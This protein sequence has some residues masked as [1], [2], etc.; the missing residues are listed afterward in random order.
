[1]TSDTPDIRLTTIA[2]IAPYVPGKSKLRGKDAPI[3]LSSNENPFGPSPKAITAASGATKKMH[4]Y[5][6]AGCDAL[7][8]A[9]AESY[10]IS[11]DRIVCGHG[12]DELITL[13]CQAYATVGDEV[14]YS[15]HGFLMY[16]IAAQRVGATPVKA[17]EKDL[18]ADVDALLAAVTERT[19]IVFIANPNNPTGSYLT[20]QEMRQL[21]EGLPPHVLL[22]I[23]AAYGEYVTA[24][25]YS[26][27]MGMVEQHQNVVMTRTFSKIYGLG[28]LRLGW[29][30]APPAIVETLQR[31]RDPFNVSSVAQAAGIAA[32]EDIGFVKRSLEH[33]T[34]WRQNLTEDL[35]SMGLHVYPSVANFVLV[36]F[37]GTFESSSGKKVDLSVLGGT[38]YDKSATAAY[39]F[40]KTHGILVRAM[41]AYGLP[42][43]LRITI[44]TEPENQ[45]L[46][47]ALEQFMDQRT[48]EDSPV[49]R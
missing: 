34:T 1:M 15:A 31:V 48:P 21:R 29:A 39:Q 38:A 30:Y 43:C 10:D 47:E 19:R 41:Q 4:R 16:P 37:P 33:T 35:S 40:L 6:E 12:S 27:G 42:D 24:G 22:V 20:K 36:K 17:P 28:G 44:G 45:A 13:L 9:I 49:I 5:P 3:K 25:D 26:S 7:R 11:A 14:L 23:D 2:E 18:R 8:D 46:L 32:L